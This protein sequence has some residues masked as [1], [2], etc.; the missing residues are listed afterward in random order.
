MSTDGIE[1]VESKTL[2]SRHLDKVDVLDR[3]ALLAMLPGNEWAT[4]KQVASFYGV[5]TSALEYHLNHDGEELRANGYRVVTGGDID[6]LFATKEVRVANGVSVKAR[7]LGL[8]NR[9]AVLNMGMLLRDSEV[10]RKVRAYLL[11]VEG[12]ATPEHRATGAELIRLQERQDYRNILHSLR[13]GGA[14]SGDDYRTV[15]NAFYLA[16]FRRNARQIKATQPQTGGTR[17]KDGKGWC[18]STVAKDFLTEHQLML[19]NNAVL[20][21]VGQLNVHYPHGATLAEMLDV[22]RI[23]TRLVAQPAVAS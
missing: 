8:F 11:A 17:R 23:S 14:E 7:K 20:I 22:V 13:L 19:L 4:V 21:A 15:Q 6:S 18:K 3:V 5:T 16:L 10:A 9:T 12:I 1:L 2:R